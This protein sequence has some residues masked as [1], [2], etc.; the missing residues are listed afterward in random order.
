MNYLNCSIEQLATQIKEIQDKSTPPQEV[1]RAII[2]RCT[3]VQKE[4]NVFISLEE[5][6]ISRE[7]E[8]L[9]GDRLPE[10]GQL[11]LA[12]AIGALGDN[13]ATSRYLT[14]CAS[15]MLHSYR[16]PFDAGVVARLEES[17]AVVAGKTN[18]DE[19]GV[20][21][22]GENSYF[23]S[24]KNPWNKKHTAG[25]GAAAAVLAGS[26]HFALASDARGELRQAASYCGVMALKPTYGRISRK[27]LL[28]YASSL[29]TIGI[30]ARH[31]ADLAAVLGAVAGQD[32]DDV[33][34]LPSAAPDYLSL[35]GENGGIRQAAVPSNWQ[36]AP[37]LEEELKDLFLDQL[38]KLEG[39][40]VKIHFVD[41]PHLQYAS[42]AAAIISAVEAFSNLSNYDGVRFGYRGEG[43]HL[44]E[45][46]AQTRSEGFSSRLK[47]FLTFGALVS[48]AKYYQDYFLRAQK[49]RTVIAG[50]LEEC[51]Q[52]FGLLLTPTT[53]FQAPEL[54][55]AGGGSA[56]SREE[57]LDPA[58]YYTAAANLAGL[59]ALTFPL[60]TAGL[61]YGLQL[62]G[63]KE[64]ELTLL[65]AGL[66]L[67]KENPLAWPALVL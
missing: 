21:C 67:E 8:R 48:T 17:G 14:T 53:P 39:V 30:A 23:N 51:L 2:G 57:L 56:R 45:M 5:D 55:A 28:D 37:Y 12:G 60:H 46:Y 22:S 63:K 52:E 26:A 33:T 18:M 65:K 11:K 58:D 10:N 7:I 27:G 42:L 15:R 44:Q 40:G 66:L 49:L 6:A 29:E 1:S 25:S 36:E 38:K 24:I 31:I 19:F 54:G 61:P 64:D 16:P 59:P 50:E 20:G 35:L 13:I 34:T 62:L 9:F 47:K 41:L 32:P 4:F 43:K 3:G